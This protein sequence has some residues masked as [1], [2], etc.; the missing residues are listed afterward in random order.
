MPPI[1]EVVSEKNLIINNRLLKY[2]GIFRADEL[3]STINRLLEE[4]GYTKRE[5]KT[6]ELV[7]EHGRRT[8]IELRPYKEMSAYLALIVKIRITLDK[9]TE[10]VE[11]V[12]GE[13]RRFQNG[14]IELIFDAWQITDYEARWGM[15]PWAFFL[16]AFVN[17]FIYTLP[18]ESG[19]RGELV[20]DTAFIYAQVKKLLDSYKVEGGKFIPEEDV[21]KSV[22]EDVRNEVEEASTESEPKTTG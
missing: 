2:K 15:K 5:K 11:E 22:E 8:F 1:N 13:K 4:K 14:D 10:V 20:G 7:T 9:V 12:R 16:K 19:Y 17:K 3:F 18:L 6:E 21:R